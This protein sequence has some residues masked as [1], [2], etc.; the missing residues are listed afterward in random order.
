MTAGGLRPDEIHSRVAD[1]LAR[2]EILDRRDPPELLVLLGRSAL[3]Q[4][5]GGG[6]AAIDQLDQL[7]RFAARPTIDLRVVRD[8]AGWH[9]GLEGP[10]TLVETS[11][12]AIVCVETRRTT[13]ILHEAVD[14]VAY[15]AAVDRIVEVSMPPGTSADHIARLRDRMRRA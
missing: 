5:L 4:D 8:H 7:L 15:R 11:T 9:P 12:A 2:Q 10:F 6:Q 3:V 14:V 1:R 13:L